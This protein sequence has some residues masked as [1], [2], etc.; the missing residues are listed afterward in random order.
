[1]CGRMDMTIMDLVEPATNSA[2]LWCDPNIDRSVSVTLVLYHHWAFQHLPQETIGLDV[3][4]E[5]SLNIPE[6]LF[7]LKFQTLPT[8][9]KSSPG[10]PKEAPMVSVFGVV[11]VVVVEVKVSVLVVLLN[12]F[13]LVFKC[14][15][16]HYD[17]PSRIQWKAS[18]IYNNVHHVPLR[19]LR[20]TCSSEPG[21]AG[22]GHPPGGEL[23]PDVCRPELPLPLRQEDLHG[24][25]EQ[26]HTQLPPLPRLPRGDHAIVVPALLVGQH[27]QPC[28]RSLEEGQCAVRGSA[29]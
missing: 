7:Q 6:I 17:Q 18:L 12:T 24:S 20:P 23:L 13:H 11:V 16:Y 2:V 9:E 21:A 27:L 25:V 3:Q 5:S 15:L 8:P 1:M 29:G 19:G 26:V 4:K 28:G 14:G 10:W 22:G